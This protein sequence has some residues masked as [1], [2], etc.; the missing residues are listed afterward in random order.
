MKPAILTTESEQIPDFKE[1]RDAR[2]D[3]TLTQSV[4]TTFSPVT[5]MVGVPCIQHVIKK[6]Q[7]RYLGQHIKRKVALYLEL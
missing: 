3:A 6:E 7:Q 1:R 5:R 2:R 4:S